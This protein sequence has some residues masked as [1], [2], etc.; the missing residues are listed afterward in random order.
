MSK[1]EFKELP[2]YKQENYRREYEMFRNGTSQY[3]RF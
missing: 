1:R 2:E 3:N